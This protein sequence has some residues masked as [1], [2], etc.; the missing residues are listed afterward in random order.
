MP[1]KKTTVLVADDDP[2]LLRLVTRNLQ[3]EGYEV[4]PVS[5]GQQALEQIEAQRPEPGAARRDD[6]Q[7]GW[8]HRLS[9]YT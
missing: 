6:A 2:H 7:V 3:F 1:V 4:L 5:D 9:S 8:L